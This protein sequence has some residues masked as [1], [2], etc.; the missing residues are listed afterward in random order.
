MSELLLLQEE[1]S[2][3]CR[4][5]YSKPPRYQSKLLNM[6]YLRLTL[7]FQLPEAEDVLRHS[8]CLHLYQQGH[9]SKPEQVCP[10]HLY[11]RH[12]RI[13]CKHHL[14]QRLLCNAMLQALHARRCLIRPPC[15][16]MFHPRSEY[17][18]L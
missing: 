14:I 9:S 2:A 17:P 7:Y 18:L 11:T 5:G 13:L 6:L 4:P 15:T 3:L 1:C 12:Q 8:C 10:G 16:C